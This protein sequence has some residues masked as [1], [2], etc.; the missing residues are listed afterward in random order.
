[1]KKHILASVAAAA[2]LTVAGASSAY[3]YDEDAPMAGPYMGIQ[4]G[5]DI[6]DFG[7]HGKGVEGGVYMGYNAPISNSMLVGAE[8][9]FNLTGAK[10]ALAQAKAKNNYGIS[11]RLGFMM[12]DASMIYVRGGYQ[13]AL[14][15][16]DPLGSKRFD[17]WSLGGGIE[18]ALSEHISVR[19]EF[20]YNRYNSDAYLGLHPNQKNMNIGIAYHF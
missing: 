6:F 19:A 17:G 1:M 16:V 10:S 8:V 18:S 3:A 14:I 9:N 20:V 2:L 4:G 12:G 5:Y 15:R 7:T 13:R 11:A